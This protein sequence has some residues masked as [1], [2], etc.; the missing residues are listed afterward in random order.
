LIRYATGAATVRFGETDVAGRRIAARA[1]PW[2]GEAGPPRF[3]FDP[4]SRAVVLRPEEGAVSV[5]PSDPEEWRRALRRPPAGPVLVGPGAPAEELRDA[6]GAAVRGALDAGRAVYLLDPE[7]SD[8]PDGPPEAFVAIHC[9][10]PDEALVARLRATADR[11]TAGLLLPIVPGWTGEPAFLEHA[12]AAAS[13]AGAGFVAGLLLSGDGE[14]RRR[15]VAARAIAEPGSE[16]RFFDRAHHGDW[17]GESRVALE[18]LEELA[19]QRGLA[20]RP[21][22]PKGASEPRINAAA[23]GAL[24]ELAERE[25]ADEHRATMLRAAVRWLDELGRDLGPVV[26]EGNFRRVFPLG[27]DIA[28]EVERALVAARR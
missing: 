18:R 19:R 20:N 12:T 28:P 9:G 26:A 16:D 8:L 27:A 10:I 25:S 13:G 14:S 5:G 11:A 4:I 1:I 6:S 21:P 23:S 24:E 15:A 2:E 7:L 22:R 3:R 17:E